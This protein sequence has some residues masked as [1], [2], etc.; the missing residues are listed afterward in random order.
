M[1]VKKLLLS[2][3]LINLAG[4][5]YFKESILAQDSPVNIQLSEPEAT[6]ILRD[7][8]VRIDPSDSALDGGSG[9]I[10]SRQGDVY[11]VL[12]AWHTVNGRGLSDNGSYTI[13]TSSGESHIV[14]VSEVHRIAN[15]DIAALQFISDRE[16][17]VTEIGSSNSLEQGEVIFAGGWFNPSSILTQRIFDSPSGEVIGRIS[18][19]EERLRS[20]PYFR[21]YELVYD[22][23]R[24]NE[25]F[26][27]GPVITSDGKLIAITGLVREADL[28]DLD[29]VVQ[30]VPVER[31]TIPAFALGFLNYL[32][33][34]TGTS[35]QIPDELELADLRISVLLDLANSERR[36][37]LPLAVYYLDRVLELSPELALAYRMRG[38]LRTSLGCSS[39]SNVDAVNDIL[40]DLSKAI[41]LEPNRSSN[42]FVRGYCYQG[43]G[44]SIK[45]ID[46][47]KRALEL[48]NHAGNIDSMRE[49]SS[50]R[51]ISVSLFEENAR[52]RGV[53][54]R[55][56]EPYFSYNN[57]GYISALESKFEDANEYFKLADENMTG[58]ENNLSRSLNPNIVETIKRNRALLHIVLGE[59]EE[60]ISIYTE[61]INMPRHM[62]IDYY[63]SRYYF[64]RAIAYLRLR[65]YDNALT[66]LDSYADGEYSE[67]LSR[68][69]QEI[70]VAST[71]SSLPPLL[72]SVVISKLDD[73]S[74]SQ[75]FNF[76]S[77]DWGIGKGTDQLFRQRFNVV[78]NVPL[79]SAAP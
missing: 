32:P 51:N 11:T 46:D 42:F 75:G 79:P 36:N 61:L 16:Y 21:G 56:F 27:G 23:E 78:N 24:K 71:N 2:L 60:A 39:F 40:M 62:F 19:P 37:N 59:W 55:E 5:T 38:E 49:D 20:D 10:F 15:L 7:I 17:A 44:D 76:V 35:F 13:Q 64:E 34:N 4:L 43:L 58:I 66:D 77:G 30:G 69:I 12:T 1:A 70:Q 29:I 54:L 68:F 22:L 8:T 73:I 18:S 45:A 6:E 3:I 52:E 9:V 74:P 48:Y 47:Y 25:G 63:P 33:E 50:S 41:E 14:P 72:D 53:L 67:A 28:N 31:F 26:S 65:E 57:L